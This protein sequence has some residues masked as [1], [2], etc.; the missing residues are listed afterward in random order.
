MW[1]A[2]LVVLAAFVAVAVGVGAGAMVGAPVS[3]DVNDE[4]AQ[5]AL[6]FAVGEHNKRTNDVFLREVAEVVQI[7]RQVCVVLLCRRLTSMIIFVCP[8]KTYTC[9]VTG[10]V[11]QIRDATLLARAFTVTVNLCDAGP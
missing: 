8:T 11:K 3:I 1:K 5:N 4:R 9:V 10:I 7:K 2:S 6:N